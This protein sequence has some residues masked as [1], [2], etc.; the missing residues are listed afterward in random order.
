M[1]IDRQQRGKYASSTIETAF[2]EWSVPRGYKRTQKTRQKWTVQFLDA[3]LPGY[4]LR[5]K[6]SR[7]CRI[8]RC[9]I[10]PRRELGCEKKT[11]RVVWSDSETDKSVARIRL[12][13]TES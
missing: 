9:R 8:W 11:S 2:S 7:V 3:S 12:I 6:L 4:E 1:S 13:M 10:R 5:I